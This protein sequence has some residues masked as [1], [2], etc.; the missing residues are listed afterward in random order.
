MK[1]KYFLRGLGSG[2]VITSIILTVSHQG[3]TPEISEEEIVKRAEE[4]GMVWEE[5]AELVA[6]VTKEPEITNTEEENENGEQEVTEEEEVTLSPEETNTPTPEPTAT[7]EPTNTPTPEPTNTPTPK[8][9]ATSTPTPTPEPTA[10]PTPFTGLQEKKVITIVS[11]MWSDKVARELEAMGAVDSALA[12]DQYLIAN[13]Y[14]ERIVVGTFEIP[15]GATYEQI[16]K[17]ITTRP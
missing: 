16:A 8:P 7:P 3:R 11:G 2:I 4:L 5:E 13:G 10:T 15:A 1:L 17:I 14:A 9:T 12:F 6:E